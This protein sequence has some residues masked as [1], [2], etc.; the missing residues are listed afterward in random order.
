MVTHFIV[1]LWSKNYFV[2]LIKALIN[3]SCG[4]ALSYTVQQDHDQPQGEKS[5]RRPLAGTSVLVHWS[6]QDGPILLPWIFMD[7]R[8]IPTFFFG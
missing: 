1:F 6:G 5:Y 2:Y 3:Y 4:A 7:L 8:C